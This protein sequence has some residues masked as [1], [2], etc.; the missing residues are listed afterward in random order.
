MKEPYKTYQRHY[1]FYL[2]NNFFKVEN[3]L[4]RS[5]RPIFTW[6]FLKIGQ[7]RLSTADSQFKRNIKK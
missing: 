3:L 5:N 1:K 7:A 6:F 2:K 4:F